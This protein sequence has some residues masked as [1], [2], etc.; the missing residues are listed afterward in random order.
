VIFTQYTTAQDNGDGEMGGARRAS[1]GGRHEDWCEVDG[2]GGDSVD[3]E[4]E[5]DSCGG[6]LRFRHMRMAVVRCL[7][8]PAV[9]IISGKGT[10]ETNLFRIKGWSKKK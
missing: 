8:M 10:G 4:V 6:G 2:D 5:V 9:G 1:G 3:E 7:Y